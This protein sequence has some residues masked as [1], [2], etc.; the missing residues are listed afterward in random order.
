VDTPV[1]FVCVLCEEPVGPDDQGSFMG[2]T[3]QPYFGP[4]HRECSLRGVL[5]GIGHLQ[6][7]LAF[8]VDKHDPDAG[9]SY[10]ES[11]LLVWSW[12]QDH[13]FPRDEP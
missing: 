1:G 11:A 12:V 5:G 10:R 8:C 6:N 3:E 9:F 4:V 2:T 7:H 13:G